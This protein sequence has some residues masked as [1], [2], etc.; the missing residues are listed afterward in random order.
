MKKVVVVGDGNYHH[1]LGNRERIYIDGEEVMRDDPE[2]SLPIEP[3]GRLFKRIRVPREYVSAPKRQTCPG[4]QHQAKRVRKVESSNNMPAMA[5]YRC[6][7]GKR[8]EIILK[9]Q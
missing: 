1:I 3:R 9:G 7:C 5:F 4:C 6:R 2:L 8:F